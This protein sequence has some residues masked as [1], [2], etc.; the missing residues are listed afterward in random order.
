MGYTKRFGIVYVDY[1]NGLSRHP[2]ASALWFSRLLKGTAA[3]KVWHKLSEP[4]ATK[5]TYIQ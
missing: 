3:D 5:G 4:A 2:K 1:K